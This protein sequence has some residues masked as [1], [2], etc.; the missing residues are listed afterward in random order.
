MD[1]HIEI[2]NIARKLKL[3]TDFYE[4]L[5]TLLT[6]IESRDQQIILSS[7]VKQSE[8]LLA[9]AEKVNNYYNGGCGTAK[10][11]IKKFES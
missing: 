5:D 11:L 6:E 1:K 2:W 9:F 3:G 10:D 7:V 8:Q 4:G